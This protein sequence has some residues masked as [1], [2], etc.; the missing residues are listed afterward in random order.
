[1]IISW[2]RNANLEK[3]KNQIKLQLKLILI[4]P[5][6]TAVFIFRINI[7]LNIVLNFLLRKNKGL[8]IVDQRKHTSISNILK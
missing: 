4:W 6:L 1:M 7:H 8:V 3:G 2:L 5:M